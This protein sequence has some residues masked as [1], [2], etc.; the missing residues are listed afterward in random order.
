MIIDTSRFGSFD[1]NDNK[2]IDFPW[3]LPGFEDLHKFVIL[4]VSNTKPIYWLQSTENKYIALPVIVSFEVLSDYSI[5]I[6]EHELEG[7]YVESKNDLLILNVTVIPEDIKKMTINLA[8][9]IVINVKHGIG[10]QIIID[11]KELPIR[12][13]G[14]E[15]VMNSIKGG[16]SNAGTL[17]EN[18]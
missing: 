12:F 8:A 18:G 7:L 14:Y 16:K 2:I 9:P 3:G 10:K 11:A 4:E 17:S 5:Y 6:K 13:P 1:I 15:A